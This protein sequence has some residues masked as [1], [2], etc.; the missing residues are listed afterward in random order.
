MEMSGRKI[1]RCEDL[2]ED[3]ERKWEYIP[4]IDIKL[5]RLRVNSATVVELEAF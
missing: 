3:H 4:E 2:L 5:N 1:A